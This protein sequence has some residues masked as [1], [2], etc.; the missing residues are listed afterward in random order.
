[1]QRI[2]G[3]KGHHFPEAQILD[4]LTQVALA[5]RHCHERRILHRDLKAQNVFLTSKNVV[6]LGDFGIARVLAGTMDKA[7]TIV[8]TP[9]YLSPEIIQNRPYGLESDIWSLGVMLYEMCA[10]K[11]PFD[12]NSLSGLALKIVHG[13]YPQIPAHYSRE[14]KTLVAQLLSSDPI[15]RPNIHKVL[16]KPSLIPTSRKRIDTVATGSVH[17]ADGVQPGA[18]K[19]HP[20]QG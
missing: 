3:A 18:H 4:W 12:A 6:K 19:E 16:R 13:T 15:K 7:K 9:Y 10:L 2:K 17:A 14:L 11:P 1:M 8:G 5:L 20:L